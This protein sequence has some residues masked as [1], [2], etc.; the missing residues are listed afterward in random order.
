MD[1]DSFARLEQRVAD[2][3]RMITELRQ[4]RETWMRE[5][6][7]LEGSVK[8][9]RTR[10]E[11]LQRELDEVRRGSVPREEFEARKGQIERR[12]QSLLSRFEELDQAG[13]ATG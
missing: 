7:E 10:N 12:V 6:E 13:T 3:V 9:L 11:D 2:A 1:N 8:E 5:R 4:E